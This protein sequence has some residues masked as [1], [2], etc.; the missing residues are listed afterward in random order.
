MDTKPNRAVLLWGAVLG[1]AFATSGG[2]MN[3]AFHNYKAR[4]N[5]AANGR[6]AL[7]IE[8]DRTPI[9]GTHF[10][11]DTATGD[12]WRMDSD[13]GGSGDWVR[14]GDAPEDVRSLEVEEGDDA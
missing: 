6:F 13:D 2:C 8:A 10:L 5:E 9:E 3:R 7:V 1:I 12:V 14:L 11:L 4:V